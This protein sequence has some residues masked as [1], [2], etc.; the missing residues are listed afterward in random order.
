[1]IW[2]TFQ[3]SLVILKKLWI[4]EFNRVEKLCASGKDYAGMGGFVS[5]HSEQVA[6]E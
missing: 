4:E 3:K 6:G 1:M 5:K 2:K